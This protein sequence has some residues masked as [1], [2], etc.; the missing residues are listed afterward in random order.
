M[1]D[2]KKRILM[3]VHD[4]EMRS[5]L[6]DFIHEDGYEVEGVIDGMDAFHKLAKKYFHLIVTDVSMPGLGG[7]EML[8]RLKRIQPW[9][10]V[11]AIPSFGIKKAQRKLL[12]Q[13]ADAYLEQPFHMEDFRRLIHN[14]L[15]STAGEAGRDLVGAPIPDLDESG[16]AR[17]WGRC[18]GDL[19]SW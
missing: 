10:C 12:E 11:V 4:K 9:A 17:W 7:W 15:S 18:G 2:E 6:R 3:I 13:N 19:W 14:K 5:L 16:W 8:P 1:S